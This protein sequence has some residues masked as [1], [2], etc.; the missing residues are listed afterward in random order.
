MKISKSLFL[1]FAG[2]GLFACSNEDVT[3]STN[4]GATVTVKFV[5]DVISRNLENPTTGNNGETF[6]V[7][8]SSGTITL[9]AQAVDEASLP[10]SGTLK[11]SSEYKFT[12]VRV[13]ESIKV[14]INE[15]IK[16]NMALADVCNTGLAEP[17]YGEETQF[18][19]DADG[20]YTVTINLDRR[21]ARLQFSGLDFTTENSSYTNL[22]LDGI[23]LNG[24]VKTEKE[25][26]AAIANDA[27][28]WNTVST[29]WGDT[30]PVFDVIGD[31]VIGSEPTEGPWPP[32]EGEQDKCYA[33]NIF[34]VSDIEELP[35][36]TVC[37]SEAVQTGVTSATDKRYARVSKYVL[38]GDKGSLE[39]IAEDGSTITAFK[40]GYI[41]NITG[42]ILADEDLGT[43]PE[44]GKDV[45]LI[46]TVKVQP[47]TLVN[48]TVEW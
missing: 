31:V 41:Y 43:T 14:V 27:D 44:G 28:A 5:G 4:Q 33:Y 40:A 35:K 15:G 45:E 17:L 18:T 10:I 30:A 7:E 16:G 25:S 23:Y 38:S 34:P 8:V 48:A 1:A 12:G 21:L 20:N 22:K 47:W 9:T 26:D 42:L 29:T 36:L 3:D 13:P 37:F 24:V 11:G 2:L 19:Q 6:P 32:A 46:A 39:G